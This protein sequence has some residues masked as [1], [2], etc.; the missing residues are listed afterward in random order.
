MY[1]RE[2]GL[3][4]EVY[5]LWRRRMASGDGTVTTPYSARPWRGG[6]PR[7]TVSLS[8]KR[9]QGKG[10]HLESSSWMVWVSTK[11]AILM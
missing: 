3:D 2:G 8:G 5:R 11:Y 9:Q 6:E 7:S 1:L 4:E 10:K